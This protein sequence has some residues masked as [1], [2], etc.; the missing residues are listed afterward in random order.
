MNEVG[1]RCSTCERIEIINELVCTECVARRIRSRDAKISLKVDQRSIMASEILVTETG[2]L[3]VTDWSIET[4]PRRPNSLS[5]GTQVLVLRI[6]L[7]P[8]V[9]QIEYR[10]AGQPM[11]MSDAPDKKKGDLSEQCDHFHPVTGY[12]C[13]LPFG[14]EEEHNVALG[15]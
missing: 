10:S 2:R 1:V 7:S 4:E 15:V 12:R 6:P 8:N 3:L 14:H 9:D 5:N 13:R 11:K